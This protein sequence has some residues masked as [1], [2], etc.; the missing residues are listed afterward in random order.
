MSTK[1]VWM[2]VALLVF[3]LSGCDS[4]P[5]FNDPSHG[6]VAACEEVLKTRLVAP[7]SYKRI[8]AVYSPGGEL[9][10]PLYQLSKEKDYNPYCADGFCAEA[11]EF[12]IRA[13]AR[14]A[15]QEKG[16]KNPTRKQ[17]EAHTAKMYR[18]GFENLQNKP[19]EERQIVFVQITY[20]AQ[21][22]FGALIRES[23][24]CM[25]SPKEGDKYETSNLFGTSEEASGIWAAFGWAGNVEIK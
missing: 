14:I 4:L 19:I 9:T 21:N 12:G 18:M 10:L 17:M 7:A 20:D 1:A 3:S 16:I 13:A 2:P 6:A 22:R 23:E 15:L 11:T 24:N 25:F 5:A 8:S